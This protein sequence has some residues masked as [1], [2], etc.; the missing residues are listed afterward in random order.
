MTCFNLIDNVKFLTEENNC[1]PTNT[2]KKK[3]IAYYQLPHTGEAAVACTWHSNVR[4][5]NPE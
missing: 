4:S 3:M 5:N 2:Y 1:T